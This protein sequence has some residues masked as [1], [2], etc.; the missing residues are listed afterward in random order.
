[1]WMLR[2][3]MKI[4]YTDHVTNEEVLRRTKSKRT[5]KDEIMKRKLA[6]FGHVVRAERLQR[7]LMDGRVEG[8]RRRGRPRRTWVTDVTEATNQRYHQCVRTV[9]RRERLQHI[10]DGDG[11]GSRATIR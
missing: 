11:Y 10:P 5:L 4:S 3:M 1:M 7:H 2:R 8:E 9:Q 6:Y